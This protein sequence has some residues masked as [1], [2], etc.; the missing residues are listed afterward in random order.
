MFTA[1]TVSTCPVI[2]TENL[3][4]SRIYLQRI[5]LANRGATAVSGPVYLV[6]EDLPEG[7]NLAPNTT[8]FLYLKLSGPSGAAITYTPLLA[9][10]LAGTP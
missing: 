10:S 5:T 9:S 4:L 3:T 8:L 1:L 6:L 7:S 2:A